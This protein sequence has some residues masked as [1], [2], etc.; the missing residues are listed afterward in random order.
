MDR[1]PD[2]GE[3]VDPSRRYPVARRRGRPAGRRHSDLLRAPELLHAPEH[4]GREAL[5]PEEPESPEAGDRGPNDAA[6]IRGARRA[7]DEPDRRPGEPASREVVRE[8]AERR[9][10][11]RVYADKA[12]ARAP[13]VAR[14][15]LRGSVVV[16]PACQPAVE[17]APQPGLRA[18]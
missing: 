18:A 11:T 16:V 9:R 2:T 8:P 10:V 15:P 14:E 5:Q 1:A 7:T 13:S 3:P 12:G 6:G 17:N 4:A